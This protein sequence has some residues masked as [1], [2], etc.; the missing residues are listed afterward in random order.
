MIRIP[1]DRLV[2]E[3]LWHIRGK[4]EKNTQALHS[5]I[6]TPIFRNGYIY[7]V[8]S[9]GQLRCLNAEDGARVWEDTTATPQER[10][11][12]IHFVQHGDD[13]WMFNELGELLIARLTPEGFS[14]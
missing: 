10:W 12:T 7:G 8:D 4:D 3:K 13:T 1:P 11:S 6:G 9:Y 5:M 2:A 14:D